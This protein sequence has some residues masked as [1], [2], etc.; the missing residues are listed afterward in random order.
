MVA[1]YQMRASIAGVRGEERPAAIGLDLEEMQ[2]PGLPIAVRAAFHGLDDEA[3]GQRVDTPVWASVHP[4]EGGPA[5]HL[6]L[7]W[8]GAAGCFTGELPGRDPGLYTVKVS[9]RNV[10]GGG[11]L[12]AV[13]TLAVIGL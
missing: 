5:E 13:E 1:A 12:S 10:P 4:D 9:A 8:D 3:A 6:R 7:V 11:D 2:E